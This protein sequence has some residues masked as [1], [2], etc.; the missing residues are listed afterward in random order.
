MGGGGH[1]RIGTTERGHELEKFGKHSTREYCYVNE[2]AG[3]LAIT[4]SE[5]ICPLPSLSQAQL[6]P[7]NFYQC[8]IMI[9]YQQSYP[10][11]L[12]LSGYTKHSGT[13]D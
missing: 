12:L 11:R 7:K 3:I 13:N 9:I 10:P 5:R 8:P 4:V 2:M 1:G 6:R